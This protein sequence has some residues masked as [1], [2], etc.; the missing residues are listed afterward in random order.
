MDYFLLKQDERCKCIPQIVNW[1]DVIN[2]KNLNLAN[3]DK[4]K[5]IIVLY[6][7]SNNDNNYIDILD[8][9]FFLVSEDMKNIIE[10]YDPNI[11]FKMVFL[12]DFKNS[13]DKVYYLT[14]LEE[15]E[16]LSDDAEMNLN[17]T[18]V[19]KLILN[20]EKIKN[21]KIFKLKESSKPMIIVR[22]DAAES[23]LRR[24]FNGICLERIEVR[25]K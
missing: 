3:A 17:K 7:K 12:T 8:Y 14:I 1:F 18:V 24:D 6:L 21:K 10:K 16:A 4:I 2:T 22:L 11:I 5:D 19:K 23:L 25:N 13:I 15:V 9:P 20:E